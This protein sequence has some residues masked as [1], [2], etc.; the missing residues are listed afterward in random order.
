M[1][2][3][4]CRAGR[5]RPPL[6]QRPPH[7]TG[8]AVAAAGVDAVISEAAAALKDTA[9]KAKD[10]DGKGTA[11]HADKVKLTAVA[12]GNAAAKGKAS[13]KHMSVPTG[14]GKA[15][16][17]GARL[18]LCQRANGA[19]ECSGAPSAATQRTAAPRARTRVSGG[20]RAAVSA[21]CV[22]GIADQTCD[23]R[24]AIQLT[25]AYRCFAPRL[26]HMCNDWRL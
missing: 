11:K 21:P 1:R 5:A 2:P 20:A 7:N 6:C 22:R 16:P 19:G 3:L 8:S 18:R 23:R 13:P 14:K 9:N 10:A 24:S 25:I 4:R 15:A 12:N 17:N 26:S